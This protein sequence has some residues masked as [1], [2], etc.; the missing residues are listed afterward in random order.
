MK[1]TKYLLP[2][3]IC[4]IALALCISC[5]HEHGPHTHTH[6]GEGAGHTHAPGERGDG[7]SHY[8]DKADRPPFTYLTMNGEFHLN[9]GDSMSQNDPRNPGRLLLETSDEK[10]SVTKM[11]FFDHTDIDKKL[12]ECGYHFIGSRPDPHYYPEQS[13]TSIWDV[14]EKVED[15]SGDCM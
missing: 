13:K 8:D 15:F 14:F 6:D 4:L 3:F 11:T 9:P 7:H 12:A 10:G 2:F 1:S 5:D